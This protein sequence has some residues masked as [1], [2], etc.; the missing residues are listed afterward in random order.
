MHF[1]TSVWQD[2]EEAEQMLFCSV[3]QKLSKVI[4]ELAG[5]RRKFMGALG[6]VGFF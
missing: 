1:W 2:R 5:K 6:L 3:K 4:M